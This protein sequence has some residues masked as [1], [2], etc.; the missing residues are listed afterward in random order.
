MPNTRRKFINLILGGGLLGWLASTLYPV[1]S[2]L[3]PPARSEARVRSV[4]AGSVDQFKLNSSKI[5][6]FGRIPV[7]LIRKI[8]GQFVALSATCTHLGCI[9]KWEEDKERFFCPCHKGIFDK[10]G[11]VLGGPP[12]R[13]LDQYKV[14]VENRLVFIYLEDKT[15]GP[16]S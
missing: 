13:P 7:I 4:K 8:D 3:I 9:I 10:T 5:I 14:E 2:Y 1:I 11:E 12:P 6:K 15:R 16:W